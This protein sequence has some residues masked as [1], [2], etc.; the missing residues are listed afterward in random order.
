MVGR[1]V[2]LMQ[3]TPNDEDW[4]REEENHREDSFYHGNE[5]NANTIG[6][7]KPYKAKGKKLIAAK[8]KGGDTFQEHHSKTASSSKRGTYWGRMENRTKKGPGGVSRSESS[9][10]L[11][12]S[13]GKALFAKGC[14]NPVESP[15][16][17]SQLD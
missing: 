16:K 14:R 13:R 11:H 12:S 5:K 15:K 2:C 9:F 1:N 3:T 6:K 4:V 8:N 7:G 10:W 17:N